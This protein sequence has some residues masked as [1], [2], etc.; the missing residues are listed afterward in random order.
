VLWPSVPRAC[1]APRW[2]AP[3][4]LVGLLG[5]CKARSSHGEL[6]PPNDAVPWDARYG[7]T[8]DDDYTR[9]AINLRGR[10]PHDVRDQRLLAARLG[11]A[12]I[13]AEVEVLQVWGEGRY[14]GR[15]EQFLEVEIQ[16][17]LMGAVIKGT[18][19]R[20]MVLVRA[21]DELPGVLQGQS[22]L[23]FLRWA[24]GQVP[25]YRHHLMPVEPEAMGYI[26]AVIEHAKA[27]GVLDAEG[28]PAQSGRRGRKHRKAS[29]RK[30][31]A[32]AEAAPEAKE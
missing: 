6:T 8:F 4:L 5:G 20:Q 9:Q 31:K 30:G 19:D 3:L 32:A 22:L 13:I 24:P 2:L 12:D 23:L 17:L 27:E 26:A 1:T 7:D 15:Q 14:Q 18:S 25:P 10:A 29:K 28:V 21:E 16:R 11:H